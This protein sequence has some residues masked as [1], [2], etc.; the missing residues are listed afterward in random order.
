MFH[1]HWSHKE[2]KNKKK[3]KK[4]KNSSLIVIISRFW[5]MVRLIK[6]L[7][8]AMVD[9]RNYF[10]KKLELWTFYISEMAAM[11]ELNGTLINLSTIWLS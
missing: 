3:I 8:L 9:K 1:K 11:S 4:S 10:V 2:K 5:K 7:T 6:K